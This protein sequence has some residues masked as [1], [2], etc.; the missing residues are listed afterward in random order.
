MRF[1]RPSKGLLYSTLCRKAMSMGYT[2]NTLDLFS[3]DVL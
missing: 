1:L 3:K 2:K